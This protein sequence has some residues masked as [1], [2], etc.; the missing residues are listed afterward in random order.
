MDKAPHLDIEGMK[1]II[2]KIIGFSNLKWLM[3]FIFLLFSW[4]FNGSAE[5]LATIYILILLDTIT[6]LRIASIK[7][8]V[9]S[10]KFFRV[11]TKC[12][13]YFIMLIIGRLVDKHV[14]IKFAAPIM[15]SFLV[16]TESISILENFSKLGYPVP[17][18]LVNKLKSY[19]E[20]KE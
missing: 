13:V 16:I 12:L 15:D 18:M 7:K 8:E 10:H 20:K 3:S 11:A 19:Y 1:E 2:F 6:G 4:I 5:I 9:S 17:T 14:P